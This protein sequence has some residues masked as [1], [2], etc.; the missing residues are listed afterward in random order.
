[1]RTFEQIRISET[2]MI[3]LISLSTNSTVDLGQKVAPPPV[4]GT[5]QFIDAAN[6]LKQHN[7][8]DGFD[9]TDRG[10]KYIEHCIMISDACERHG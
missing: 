2:A 4:F 9:N 7:L 10:E 1:M 5:S 8:S 6:E 3:L